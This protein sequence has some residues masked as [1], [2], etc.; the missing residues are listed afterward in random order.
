MGRNLNLVLAA[1]ALASASTATLAQTPLGAGGPLPNPRVGGNAVQATPVQPPRADQTAAVPPSPMPRPGVTGDLARDV[2]NGVTPLSAPEVTRARTEM[3]ARRRAGVAP[4]TQMSAPQTREIRVDLS[5]GAAPI[6]VQVRP[7]SGAV[8]SFQ[9]VAGN[10]WPIASDA[11]FASV[12]NFNKDSINLAP[13]SKSAISVGLKTEDGGGIAVRLQGLEE[14]VVINVLP[15][16]NKFDARV[17]MTMP[18]VLPGS[19]G[20]AGAAAGAQPFDAGKL[21][22][23]LYRT[24]PKGAV[25]LKVT[26]VVGVDAWQTPDRAHLIIRLP[27]GGTVLDQTLINRA[28]LNGA[29]AVQIPVTSSLLLGVGGQSYSVTLGG[30]DVSQ[31]KI[32]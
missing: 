14:A 25:Q 9:D 8:L 7:G 28:A 18:R 5:P 15:A 29:V 1:V 19:N 17:T 30:M 10:P 24:P 3:E 32:K 6:M 4:L 20:M 2:V 12:Q 21:T 23:Y 22:A 27:D 13:F 26:G 16:Q 11:D 31:V